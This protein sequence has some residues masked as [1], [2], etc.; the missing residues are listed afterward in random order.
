MPSKIRERGRRRR[1]KRK[2]KEKKGNISYPAINFWDMTS[3]YT[4]TSICADSE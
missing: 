3:L 1:R 4:Y 2:K